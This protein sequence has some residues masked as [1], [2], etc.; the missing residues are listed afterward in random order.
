M[1]MAAVVSFSAARENGKCQQTRRLWKPI[2][3]SF[4]GNYEKKLSRK[5]K[6][7]RQVAAILIIGAKLKI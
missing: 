4:Q 7:S 6:F 3:T 1:T 5:N 2:Y